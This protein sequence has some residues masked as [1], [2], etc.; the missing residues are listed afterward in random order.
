MSDFLPAGYEIPVESNYMKLQQGDN[1]LRVLG[2]AIIGQEYWIET[3]DGRKPIRKRQGERIS[4]ADIGPDS[5][6]KHFWA[7]PVYNYQ[8]KRIQILELTQKTI[9]N[10][11]QKLTSS[12][13]WGDPK[14]Y[15]ITI[16]KE[17]E[18]MQTEYSVVP[19]PK[20]KLDIG[21]QQL[22]NDMHIN[23]EALYEGADPF[24]VNVDV[25]FQEEMDALVKEK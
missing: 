1:K 13:D 9:M 25:A 22:Y 16:T 7:F 21:I 15:D 11:I 10:G 24:A 5:S 18:M 4:P 2:S 6:I 14:D 17:G 20:K 23:L 19:S 3:K 12:E 8:D